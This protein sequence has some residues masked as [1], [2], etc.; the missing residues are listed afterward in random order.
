MEKT[1]ER[2]KVNWVYGIKWVFIY[3]LFVLLGFILGMI[4]QQVLF[5][6]EIGKLLSYTDLEINLNFN[7]TK[8]AEELNRTFIPA[9]KEAFNQTV[10]EQII[11]GK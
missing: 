5:I 3:L 1:K 7:A 4:Y 9:W 8:F 6:Q 2:K 11:K 10:Q